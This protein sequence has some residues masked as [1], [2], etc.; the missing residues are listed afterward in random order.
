MEIRKCLESDIART[1]EFYDKVVKWLDEHMNYPLWKYRI[2][3]CERYAREMALSGGQY[4][5]EEDGAVIA[6]FALDNDPPGSLQQECWSRSLVDGSYL[7]IHAMAIDPQMQKHGLGSEIV[8]FCIDKARS[9]GYKAIR[10]D[11]VPTNIPARRFFEKNGFSYAG[12][13]DL[14]IDNI[15][16]FSLYELNL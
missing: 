14:G 5:C 2:Y 15:P 13:L 4:I 16:A 12:D 6:A 3:P 11:V 9:D 8:R 7:V 1:G 10:V